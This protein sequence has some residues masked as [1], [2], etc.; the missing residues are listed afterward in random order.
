MER[1]KRSVWLKQAPLD[2]DRVRQPPTPG[3]PAHMALSR[4]LNTAIQGPPKWHMNIA[5]PICSVLA[6]TERQTH[7]DHATHP[8][9]ALPVQA[10]HTS[11]PP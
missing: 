3:D 5:T 10:L 9:P 7:A 8:V 11:R 4:L 1:G 6:L 2:E